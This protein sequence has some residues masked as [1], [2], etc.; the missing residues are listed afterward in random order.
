MSSNNRVLIV[1]DDRMLR[2]LVRTL[3][4]LE[5]F[6]VVGEAG[7]GVEALDLAAQERP[8]LVILDYF[9]PR[10]DGEATSDALRLLVPQARILA[11]S[12]GLVQTPQ[13]ADAF[14]QKDRIDSVTREL[15]RLTAERSYILY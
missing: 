8:D 14:L 9:M 12:A 4:E 7:D 15:R 10:L 13:W 3:C 6:D 1:D 11:F 2:A 5:G